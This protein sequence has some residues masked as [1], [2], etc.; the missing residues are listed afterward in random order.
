MAGTQKWLDNLKF[1]VSIGSQGNDNI[2]NFRYT[3]TYT[4]ENANGEVSTV[5]KNKGSENITWETNSNFNTGIEFSIFRGVLSGGIEYF[6]RRTTDMLLSF[7]TPPS[8][9]YSSYYANVGDMRNSGV[10]IELNFMPINREH[11]Q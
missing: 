6:L 4:I 10:E 3:N 11:V 1:K 2:G 9:G 7:P 8:M 5:F